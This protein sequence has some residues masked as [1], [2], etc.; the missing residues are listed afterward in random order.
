MPSK[1]GL[2]FT[3][4][5]DRLSRK[6]RR[7]VE[8]RPMMF[9]AIKTVADA[10]T[11]WTAR[12]NQ[13]YFAAEAATGKMIHFSSPPPISDDQNSPCFA[14]FANMTLGE[15]AHKAGRS[16]ILFHHLKKPALMENTFGEQCLFGDLAHHKTVVG[17]KQ[18][19]EG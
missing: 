15:G 6:N 5:L 8:K 10:Y 7:S 2:G 9:S 1:V 12:G 13:P 18:T 16:A 11:Q 3:P 17:L 14:E 4:N 19:F